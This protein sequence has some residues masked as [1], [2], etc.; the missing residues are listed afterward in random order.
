M[1]WK[2]ITTAISM[3]LILPP[4]SMA[5]NKLEHLQWVVPFEE[6]KEFRVELEI[7][8][9]DLRIGKVQGDNLL[10]AKIEYLA[11]RGK[12]EMD[13]HRT[14]SIGKLHIISAEQDD[15]KN[16]HIRGI[17]KDSEQWE[18]LLSSKV[19]MDLTL[20]MGLVDGIID[21][22]GMR[23]IN[24][25]LSGGLSDIEISFNE[26]NP[27]E[28]AVAK[29]EVGLGE[30]NGIKLG[31]A[32]FRKLTL[33]N[34]LGRA[35]LDLSGLW[36]VSR[37]DLDL[38]VGLGKAV[39]TVPKNLGIEVTAEDNFLSSVDLDRLIAKISDGVFRTA[40]W[41]KASTQLKI[42]AE[43]GLGSIKVKI[44]E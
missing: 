37:A 29:I 27:E 15:E 6:I 36:R 33:D 10:E 30:F 32:N 22:T 23:I 19:P 5:Q 18:L 8:A 20:E 4:I 1:K 31:N 34:G 12:P 40:N 17:H 21:L 39:V 7:G 25:N 2:W 42:L 35:N 24:L 14:G 16:S 28:I 9:A 11:S 13:Y 44:A 26:P 43:A 41:D 38:Q 3:M